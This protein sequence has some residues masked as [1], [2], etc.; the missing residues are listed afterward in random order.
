M[1]DDDNLYFNFDD[2]EA[3]DDSPEAEEGQNRSFLI[4]AIVLGAVFVLGICA[5]VLFLIFGRQNEPPV[6]SD[7]ALTNQANIAAATM[8]AQF[9][10]DQAATAAA[11]GE[12][13]QDP[14]I[15]ITEPP[16]EQPTEPGGEFGETPTPGGIGVTVTV[17]AGGTEEPTEEGTTEATSEGTLVAEVTPI[18]GTQDA[19]PTPLQPAGSASP[20]P[21]STSGI[22]QVT[23]GGPTATPTLVGGGTDGTGGGGATPTQIGGGTATGGS[24]G[25]IQPTAEATLP[26]T[27]FGATA[28]LASAGILAMALMVVVVVVRYMRM[29]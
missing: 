7:N 20:T 12:P 19:T 28:G 21:V 25:P 1:E 22:I 16:T 13:T 24:G 10:A 4:G 14:G 2:D 23:N 18:V 27:G 29:R 26:N 8:T 6:V 3:D 17:E 5:V 15:D 11:G 9:M